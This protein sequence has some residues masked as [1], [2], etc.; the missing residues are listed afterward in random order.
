MSV[1]V[2][3]VQ[4]TADRRDRDGAGGRSGRAAMPSTRCDER[5]PGTASARPDRGRRSARCCCGCAAVHPS[6]PCSATS[7]KTRAPFVRCPEYLKTVVGDRLEVQRLP[8]GRAL[9]RPVRVAGRC[10]SGRAAGAQ[11]ARVIVKFK[12]IPACCANRRP[13]PANATQRRRSRSAVVASHRGQ[14]RRGGETRVVFASG[15]SSA[16]L[17]ERLSRRT[18]STRCRIAQDARRCQ[19]SALRRRAG[20]QQPQTGGPVAGQWYLR[21]PPAHGTLGHQRRS[22]LGRAGGLCPR[23]WWWRCSTPACAWITRIWRANC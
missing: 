3:L 15:M 1:L 8:P 6:P 7:A 17:A 14:A 23:R 9:A 16:T 22:G 21:A 13:A 12:P 2:K 4:P 10:G 18:S 19:Q 11:S 5:G 20:G